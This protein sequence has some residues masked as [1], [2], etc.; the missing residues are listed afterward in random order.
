MHI[1]LNY[2]QTVIKL[3]VFDYLKQS[4][5]IANL[6]FMID[7]SRFTIPHEY[8]KKEITIHCYHSLLVYSAVYYYNDRLLVYC[9]ATAEPANDH[10]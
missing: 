2:G 8:F 1:E 4:N 6:P 3:R 7:D 5:F 9:T 10:L